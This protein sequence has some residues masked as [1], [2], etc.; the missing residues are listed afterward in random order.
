MQN[1]TTTKV[2][3]THREHVIALEEAVDNLIN[4]TNNESHN[5]VTQAPNQQSIMEDDQGIPREEKTSQQTQEQV[6]I[7]EIS[8]SS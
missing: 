5:F 8:Q 1:E 3:D 6:D 2:V 4:I 7:I